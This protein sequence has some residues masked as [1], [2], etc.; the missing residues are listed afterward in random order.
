MVLSSLP[1]SSFG[2]LV[3]GEEE[4]SFAAAAA[5]TG[6]QRLGGRQ[7]LTLGGLQNLL[8]DALDILDDDSDDWMD[9]EEEDGDVFDWGN[10]VFMAP[11]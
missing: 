10:H 9:N 6:D 1:S 3:P 4:N 11:Q 7:N 8:Q 2:R 5:T